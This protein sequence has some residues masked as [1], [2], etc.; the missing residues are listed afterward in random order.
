MGRP[1]NPTR[2]QSSLALQNL[3]G[4]VILVVLAFHSMLAYLGSLP[5]GAFAF[6]ASPY[7]WRAFPIVD[8][9]RWFGFDIFCAWQ[10]VSLMS[11]MFFL[12]ALFT[13]PSLARKGRRYFLAGRILRLG[14]PFALAI[15]LIMPLALYPV[16][17]ATAADRAFGAY[18]R[19]YLA[20]PFWP[21]G[22]M[23]FIWQLLALAVLAAVLHR[24]APGVITWLARRCALAAA[25]PGWLFAALVA[26][27]AAGYVPMALAFTPMAWNEHGPLALQYSRSVLYLVYYIAGLGVGAC[28]LEHGVLAAGGMLARQWPVWLAAS[29]ASIMTWMG[30]MGLAMG[31]GLSAP[32]GLQLAVDVSF[33][34][35]CSS[36]CFCVLAACIRFGRRPSRIMN[37]LSRNAFGMY[38]CHYIF[39][40]WLQYALLGLAVF[41]IA[42]AAIVFGG[43]VLMA[44]GTSS[45]MTAVLVRS[46]LAGRKPR[47]LIPQP[48]VAG[49]F[50]SRK[51]A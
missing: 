7:E 35:A 32:L 19:H 10:D 17:R 37:S 40:V 15:A 34:V 14:I 42:K 39:A 46:R 12:S 8:R 31:Y 22:P 9:H 25:R 38:L 27:S 21:N 28:G 3:R 30:L 26:V 16:Y 2:G 29:L 41:A 20:L 36:G 49:S 6:D 11:L 50:A 51:T 33:A 5:A 45:A 1:E 48:A 18:V 47:G 13:W 24:L 43:T 44:W 23:W 4:V